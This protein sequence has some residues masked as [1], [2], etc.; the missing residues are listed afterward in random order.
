MSKKLK[1]LK[2]ILLICTIGFILMALELFE[3]FSLGGK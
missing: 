1:Q 2:I 3:I